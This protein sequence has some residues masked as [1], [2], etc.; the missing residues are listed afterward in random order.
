MKVVLANYYHIPSTEGVGLSK[1][2]LNERM[3]E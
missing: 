3:N 2:L 1:Y